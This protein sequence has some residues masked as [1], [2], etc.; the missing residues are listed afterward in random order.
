MSVVLLFERKI[1]IYYIPSFFRLLLEKNMLHDD[2]CWHLQPSLCKIFTQY[3]SVKW[4]SS[5]G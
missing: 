2:K 5:Q 4:C 3:L 1:N